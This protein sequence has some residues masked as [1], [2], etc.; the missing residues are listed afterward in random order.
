MHSSINSQIID[1][2]APNYN[3]LNH[4]FRGFL[5]SGRWLP[6]PIGTAREPLICQHILD[7]FAW[8]WTVS[9]MVLIRDLN[10]KLSNRAPPDKIAHAEGGTVLCVAVSLVS[11]L[12]ESQRALSRK[13][14]NIWFSWSSFGADPSIIREFIELRVEMVRWPCSQP[15]LLL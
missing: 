7:L 9:L 4:I 12:N 14:R 8:P 11:K 3:Q 5:D 1:G 10:F 6:K 2:S 15:S 13:P